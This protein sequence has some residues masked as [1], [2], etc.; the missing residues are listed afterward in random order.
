M[1]LLRVYWVLIKAGWARALEYRAQIVIWLISFLFPLIMMT[2][3]LA[4]VDQGGP[5]AGWTRTDFIA[6]YVAALLVNRLTWAPV[7]W[8]W[9]RDLRTGDLSMKLVKPLDPFHHFVSEQIG[10]QIFFLVLV[11]PGICIASLFVPAIRYPLTAPRLLAF[12]AAVIG[13]FIM[14]TLMGTTFAMLGFW[15]TQT[16]N[17]FSLW[18]GVGQFLSGW[19][20]PLAMFPAGVRQ[21]AYLL[22]FRS[23][24][25]F[26]NDILMGRLDL[27]GTGYGFAVTLFWLMVFLAAYRFLWRRGL[28]RYDA[29][30]G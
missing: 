28:R 2:V 10:W 7:V 1:S 29:V 17:L 8:D 5:A 3:W 23:L 30:G 4:V 21:V 22:P 9:D 14:N 19:I 18:W 12:A 11:V 6:Y 27:G 26:T 20:A 24:L 25:G 15:S 16:R 13:G